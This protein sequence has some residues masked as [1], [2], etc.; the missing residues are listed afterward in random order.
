MD[1]QEPADDPDPGDCGPGV[2]DGGNS[3][4]CAARRAGSRKVRAH[5][6]AVSA[7]S[8]ADGGSGGDW[9]GWSAD[10]EFLRRGC[11][12]AVALRDS[13]GD[14]DDEGADSAGTSCWSVRAAEA[15]PLR[16]AELY[17]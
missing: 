9:G 11:G 4:V 17:P 1:A 5:R 2:F 14:G 13:D 8:G 10:F 7:S 16:G 3:K 6:D 15:G 12:A